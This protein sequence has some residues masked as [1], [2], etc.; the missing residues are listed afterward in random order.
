MPIDYVK[1]SPYLMSFM[2]NYKLKRRIE[3]YF[4]RNP[5]EIYK[6]NKDTFWLNEKDIAN[7]NAIS[8]NNARLIDLM[9]HVLKDNAEKLLWIPP[10]KPYYP[11]E[12]AFKDTDNFSKTLIF[13]S[14]EMVPRMISSL[15]S[16]EVERKTIGKLNRDINYFAQ[17]RYPS[18]RL[19]FALREGKP[20]QMALL[21]L[22]Y[23][24]KFL[25][26]AYNPIDCLN[27]KLSLEDIEQEIKEKIRK[28]L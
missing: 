7:Y 1:S 3:S 13:S 10:S 15:V 5:Q 26:D 27:R 9:G 28:E 17:R 22:I 21:T 6:M 2:K 12:G 14:W 4:K 18:P 19:N 11:L 24:S 16:Y 23:P 25:I 20:A 8:Y